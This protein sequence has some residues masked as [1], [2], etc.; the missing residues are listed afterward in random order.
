VGPPGAEL[1][2]RGSW[3]RP[4]GFLHLS[5]AANPDSYAG[6]AGQLLLAVRTVPGLNC[7][8]CNRRRAICYRCNGLHLRC[9]RIRNGR[10]ASVADHYMVVAVMPTD[11]HFSPAP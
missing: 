6:G 8:R 11:G 7:Y 4:T 3:D 5:V 1:R 10:P 9:Y 2:V